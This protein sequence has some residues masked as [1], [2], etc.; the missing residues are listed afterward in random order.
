VR[1]ASRHDRGPTQ[2]VGCRGRTRLRQPRA[3][4][5]RHRLD[6]VRRRP[7]PGRAPRPGAGS[8]GRLC[9]GRR[10][11]HGTAPSRRGRRK[12]ARRDVPP[13]SRRS[14]SGCRAMRAGTSPNRSTPIGS[15]STSP[16]AATMSSPRGGRGLR[17][18]TD[19]V[20]ATAAVGLQRPGLAPR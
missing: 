16:S 19:G 20:P 1:A 17:G 12:L 10:G 18:G 11:A 3:G 5:V 4:G 2:C 14:C 7:H 13:T 15:C 8:H 9:A 6:R